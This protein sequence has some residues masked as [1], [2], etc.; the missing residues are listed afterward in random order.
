MVMTA[1][2][3]AAE[4]AALGLGDGAKIAVKNLHVRR[5]EGRREGGG[6]DRRQGH[7]WQ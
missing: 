4:A 2:E 1:A 6:R 5:V 3:A 7:S